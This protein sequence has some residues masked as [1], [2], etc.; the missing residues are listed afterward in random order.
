MVNLDATVADEISSF[1]LYGLY[2]QVS[3]ADDVTE[4]DEY[5][6]AFDSK[7]KGKE[8][9]QI[10]KEKITLAKKL[11]YAIDVKVFADFDD[12]TD[13]DIKK[14]KAV[15]YSLLNCLIKNRWS[16]SIGSRN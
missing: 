2:L 5:I 4:A 3:N 14:E 6:A 11:F 9:L 1:R 15:Y 12:Q 13:D 7:F 16:V 8:T 10:I